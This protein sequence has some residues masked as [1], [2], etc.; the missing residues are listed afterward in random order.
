VL[1]GTRISDVSVAARDAYTRELLGAYARENLGA[2][3]YSSVYVSKATIA[4]NEK[5]DPALAAKQK[6]FMALQNALNARTKKRKNEAKLAA[7]R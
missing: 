3:N 1:T 7:T 4:K 6:N 5:V 2:R